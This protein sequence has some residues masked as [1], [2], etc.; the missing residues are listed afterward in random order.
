MIDAYR[1]VQRAQADK[2]RLR[3]E[4]EAYRNDILPRARGQAA[5]IVQEAEG[6]KRQTVSKARGESSRFKAVYEQ[7][8]SAPTVTRQRLYLE[9][10]E[11]ILSK[12]AKV[13]ID[14]KASGSGV[15]PYL[16]LPEVKK[17]SEQSQGGA[18]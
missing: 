5:M 12:N 10:M 14:S 7:Y 9:A 17:R 6:Y 13:V 3:N 1:D 4:A 2:E 16:P 11:E 18:K 15:V 8:L